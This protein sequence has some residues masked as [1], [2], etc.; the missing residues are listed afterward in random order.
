MRER[1]KAK[2]EAANLVKLQKQAAEFLQ[3][4]Q[5]SK[6]A[7]LTEEQIVSVFSTGEKVEKTPRGSQP[8]K[9]KKKKGKK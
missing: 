9:E 5:Q 4:Q 1:M 3:Q 8:I 7:V 6:P 2:A